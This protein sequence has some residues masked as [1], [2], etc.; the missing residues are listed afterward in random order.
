MELPQ[1]N[2]I[3]G[4]QRVLTIFFLITL[5]ISFTVAMGFIFVSTDMTT[6][7][8]ETLY[9]GGEENNQPRITEEEE[10]SSFT[11][12]WKNRNAGMKFAKSLKEMILTTHLHLL[13]ISMLLFLIGGIFS[14]ST[15]PQHL[16]NHIIAAGF[17]SLL[18]DYACMWGVRYITAGF[19]VGVYI[20]GFVQSS[21]IYLQVGWSLNDLFFAKA[22][23]HNE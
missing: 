12:E 2:K 19:S 15:F 18:G 5:L 16:K 11:N 23:Q 1:L 22:S 8:I 13:S 17:L 6:K 14:L 3:P 9:R 10:I 21:M 7:G 20:F 4:T